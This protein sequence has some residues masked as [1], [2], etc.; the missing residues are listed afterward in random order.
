VNNLEKKL[1]LKFNAN[2]SYLINI[3]GLKFAAFL[4]DFE[5]SVHLAQL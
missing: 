4:T 1:S 5:S 3:A 2:S